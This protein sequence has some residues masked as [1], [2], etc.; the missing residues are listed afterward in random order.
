MT[1]CLLCWVSVAPRREISLGLFRVLQ[2]ALHNARKHSG[3]RHFNVELRV[4]PDE[5]Q[6]TVRDSGVGFDLDAAVKGRG[7]GLTSMKERLK[8]VG[9][10]VSINSQRN[11]GTT[12]EARVSLSSSH[13]AMRAAG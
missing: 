6:L 2:E 5:V 12:I 1:G 11:G 10:I 13:D 8:L 7:L 3:V 9:G 4:A